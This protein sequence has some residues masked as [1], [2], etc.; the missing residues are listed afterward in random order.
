MTAGKVAL[1]VLITFLVTA[2]V[3]PVVLV[4]IPITQNDKVGLTFV[5]GMAAVVFAVLWLVF[6]RVGR[7]R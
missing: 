2:T 7:R 3:M 1:M 5:C 4:T 6:A